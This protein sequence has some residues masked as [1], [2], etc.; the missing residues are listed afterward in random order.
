MKTKDMVVHWVYTMV[1]RPI[2]TYAA[3]VW[4]PKSEY[5]TSQAKVSKLIAEVGLSGYN[6]THENGSY[7]CN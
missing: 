2:I 5:K 6:Q 3:M 4:W 7:S 1:V